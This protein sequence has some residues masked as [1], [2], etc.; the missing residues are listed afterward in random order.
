MGDETTCTVH[1]LRC[2]CRAFGSLAAVAA[3][4][5]LRFLMRKRTFNESMD[6]R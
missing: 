5:T 4:Q 3:A 1:E 2:G 6:R